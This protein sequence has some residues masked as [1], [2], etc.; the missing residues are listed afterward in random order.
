[1][2]DALTPSGASVPV[3]G[4]EGLAGVG[5]TTLAVH[6][7]HAVAAGFPDGQL[8]VDLGRPASRWPSCCAASACRTRGCP[9][10]SASA[11]RCGGR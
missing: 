1:M 2:A 9:S 6:V 11:W 8:F 5:K 10:R 3:I 4:V 7:G